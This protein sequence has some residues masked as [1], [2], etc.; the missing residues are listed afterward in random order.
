[1]LCLC[2]ISVFVIIQSPW[3]N[4]K[5]IRP[6][7]IHK[8]FCLQRFSVFALDVAGFEKN[9]RYLDNE[10]KISQPI[11]NI[12]FILVSK[13]M[14]NY[15]SLPSILGHQKEHRMLRLDSSP[16]CSLCLQHWP[17]YAIGT[18]IAEWEKHLFWIK[19]TRLESRQ[20]HSQAVCLWSHYI[21]SLNLTIC[22]C[23]TEINK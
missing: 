14:K 19:S 23:K 6:K 2:D 12:Q 17:R 5:F 13:Y 7:T 22:L 20:L 10:Y 18:S 11:K 1:M 4:C 21:N 16:V 8:A 9:N 3:L 15:N